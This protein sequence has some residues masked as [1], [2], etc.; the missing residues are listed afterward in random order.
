[1][2]KSRSTNIPRDPQVDYVVSEFQRYENYHKDR[3]ATARNIIDYWKN[4]PPQKGLDWSNA[5]NVPLMVEGEQVITPRLFTALFPNDAPLDVNV[6]GD[7]PEQQGI[8]IKGITQHYFRVT[9]A[10]GE[11]YPAMQ[12]AVLLGTGYIE[13]GSWY[14]R[15]GWQQDAEGNR[16][17]VP[18]ESR[19]DCKFVNFFEMF[20][21]PAKR[22]VNDPL[23]LIR[24]R[25][26][27]AET[28]KRL[29]NDSKFDSTKLAEALATESADPKDSEKYDQSKMKRYE[30]LDYWGP[31]DESY[32]ED[33]EQKTRHAVPYW[34]IVINRQ[35][36]IRNIPNPY[37]HQMAPFCKIKLF[38]D[39]DGD[40]WFGFGVGQVGLPTQE[41]INKIVNQRLDNVDLVLNKQGFYNKFDTAINTKKLQISKPGQWHAV[42]DVNGSIKWMDTP[43]VTASSYREEELAKNDF[44]E[45]TGAIA[46]LLP[47]VGQE[48]RTAMGIQLLQGAAGMRFRPVLRKWEIDL[49]QQLAMFFFSNLKQFM[50]SG[51]WIQVT[52]KNG[53][54][55][56]IRVTPQQIQ[57]KVFFIPTGISETINKETM[58]GQLLRFK[59][60][61]TQDPTVNR[62]EINKRIAE[63]MGF[64]D[65][66]KL[67]TPQRQGQVGGLTGDDQARIQQM[68]AEGFTPRQIKEQLIG[69]RPQP[70]AAGGP[71]V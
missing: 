26:V 54:V 25:F 67:L 11:S 70:Q 19:P 13:G 48:H 28:L 50:T 47:E 7:A 21:H 42:S 15:R 17:F 3:F 71:N 20:P 6:E 31:W 8:I 41:R 38:E 63:I 27:D 62:Q 60:I 12:Q 45:A 65:I 40:Q 59:E 61:T 2:A 29:A 5:I 18:I 64:K 49:V 46:N 55:A 33:G 57:A 66:H 51:E 53:E 36:A 44:R 14:F 39:P 37:N 68:A 32:E 35:I 9:N 4:K 58:I 30:I 10:L 56:P 34:I 1:M 22:T 16:Y 69:P 43:D 24:Q 23:P 52:G